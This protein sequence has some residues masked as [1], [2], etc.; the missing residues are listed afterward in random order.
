MDIT[1]LADADF[2]KLL[3]GKERYGNSKLH[4]ISDNSSLMTCSKI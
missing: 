4:W 1:I 2:L 3:A